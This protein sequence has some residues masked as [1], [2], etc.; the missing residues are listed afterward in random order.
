MDHDLNELIKSEMDLSSY[1][2]FLLYQLLRGIKY[3]HSAKII[4]RDLVLLKILKK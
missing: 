4:H 2:K 3:L 1:L